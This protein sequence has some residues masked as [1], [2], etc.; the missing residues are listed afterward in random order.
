MTKENK[1]KIDDNLL[2]RRQYFIGPKFVN[3]FKSWNKIK[4]GDRIRI[5]AHPDLT[6]TTFK[7][8]ET[9]IALLGFMF[10]SEDYQANLEDILKNIVKE[11][12]SFNDIIKATYRYAGRWILIYTNKNESKLLHDPGGLRQIFYCKNGNDVWC[13]AQPHILAS[14]LN[15]TQKTDPNILNY[16]NSK[17]Y[18]NN[19][20][21]WVGN[22][23][24]F[25]DIYHSYPNHYLDLNNCNYSRY[26]PDD[27]ID[28]SSLSDTVNSC[29]KILIGLLKAANCRHDLAQA[30]TSGWDTRLMLAASKDIK[31]DIYY[32]V[33]KFDDFDDNH[34]DIRVPNKLS[35]Q[36][37]IDIEI[38]DCSK[39]SD[40]FNELHKKS[41]FTHQND[42]KKKQHFNYFSDFQGRLNISGNANPLIKVTLPRID[43]ISPYSLAKLLGFHKQKYALDK[44]KEWLE[45]ALPISKKYNL[46]IV[47]LFYWEIRFGS[48]API[49]FSE[50]DLSNEEFPPFN[51][52]KLIDLFLSVD[53]KYRMPSSMLIFRKMIESLWP[54]VLSQPVNPGRYTIKK[55]LKSLIVNSLFNLLKILGLY[56]FVRK[57]YR[58]HLVNN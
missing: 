22:E 38:L 54:E 28:K 5:T 25:Q 42:R 14:I 57:K 35:S 20:H 41:L 39:Y 40:K 23:T 52:R 50:L 2:Y 55:K 21:N 36:I 51:C 13:S 37:G 3:H 31:N 44:I 32:Y 33:H 53:D 16:I 6:I 29:N 11:T 1:P 27:T 12:N 19:E 48:W 15:K 17:E 8:G 46:H 47:H 43:E 49:Y 24:L 9:E 18:E 4:V 26:W 7:K 45:H 56:N 30:V 10:D 34:A 58:T